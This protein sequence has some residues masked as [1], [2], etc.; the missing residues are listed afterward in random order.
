MLFEPPKKSHPRSRKLQRKQQGWFERKVSPKLICYTIS[1]YFNEKQINKL[2]ATQFNVLLQ[3]EIRSQTSVPQCALPCNDASS[4]EKSRLDCPSHGILATKLVP[5]NFPEIESSPN[6]HI[7]DMDICIYTACSLD[8]A[9]KFRQHNTR[10]TMSSQVA[11]S[12][13]EDPDCDQAP[14]FIMWTKTSY[15]TLWKLQVS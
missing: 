7:V 8:Q 5:H 9:W 14:P 12:S 15:H 11:V 4:K 10:M 2:C 13:K 6:A 3:L 1:N